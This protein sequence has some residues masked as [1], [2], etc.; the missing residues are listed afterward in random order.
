MALAKKVH[1]LDSNAARRAQITFAL[2]KGPLQT[3]IYENIKEFSQW[4]PAEGLILLKDDAACG[5]EEVQRHL[6]TWG[7]SLPIAMY[8]DEPST[9][10]IVQAMLAGALDY[11][12]WPFDASNVENT[13]NKIEKES[14]QHLQRLRKQFEAVGLVATLSERERQVLELL[15]SGL[16]TKGIALDLGISP[17]TVEIHRANV[18]IKLNARSSSEAVRIGIY[19]GLDDR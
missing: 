16:S 14:V 7:T 12:E 8:S 6:R 1:V 9:I 5:I 15:V 17:R 19:A 18:M 11:L 4:P 10:R 2:G 13:F 3:Q